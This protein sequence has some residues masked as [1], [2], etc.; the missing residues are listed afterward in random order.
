LELVVI[1]AN[2]MLVQPSVGD[3]L[4]RAISPEIT[5]DGVHVQA[6]PLT[7]GE[8]AGQVSSLGRGGGAAEELEPPE[9]L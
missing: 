9:L 2:T 3:V 6:A 4:S 1:W 7:A 5:V 8:P